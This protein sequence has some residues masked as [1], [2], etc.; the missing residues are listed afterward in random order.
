MPMAKVQCRNCGLLA[1][2]NQSTRTL[3]EI[4]NRLREHW[5]FADEIRNG[6]VGPLALLDQSPVCCADCSAVAKN[7]QD[8]VNR[9]KIG[10]RTVQVFE[11]CITGILSKKRTCP[12]FFQLK[13]AL[14]PKDHQLLKSSN[15]GKHQ[16]HDG[17]GKS[18]GTKIQNQ[19]EARDKF[20]YEQMLKGEPRKTIRAN[21]ECSW[22]QIE[23]DQGITAAA[24]RYAKRNNKTWPI[25][26]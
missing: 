13:P 21:L 4:E 2:R 14:S 20:C 18:Q 3:D 19:N 1:I 5:Q 7:F 22:E 16:R 26:R 6:L 25:E 11:D 15:T 10:S 23:S 17:E 24:K 9:A 8:E 12:S